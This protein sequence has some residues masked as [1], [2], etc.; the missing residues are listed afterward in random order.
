MTE[1]KQSEFEF[2]RHFSRRVTADFEGGAH[3][4]DGGLLLL[5]E[6]AEK[7]RLL[8][9]LG[10]CFRDGRAP[11]RRRHTVEE[12]LG[13]RIFALAAGYEDLNDHDE[14]RR[15]PLLA[16]AAGRRDPDEALAS[17]STLCRLEAGAAEGEGEDRYKRVGYDAAAI[18]ALLVELFLESYAE[19]PAE[20]VLDLDV[21]DTPLHGKQEGRFFHGY[22]GCYCYLPLYIFAGERL[23][24]VRL[25]TADQ[26]A[27]AG[28]L[29]EVERLVAAIRA[30]WPTT[31]IIVRGDAGFCRERLLGWCEQHGVDYV[32]GLAR[33]DRLRARIGEAMAAAQQE[34]QQTGRPARAFA[35]LRYRT[36]QSWSRSRRV[37]AKAEQ[38]ADKENPRYVVTSLEA[39][40]WGPRELYERLYCARGEMEN[41]IKEQL[42]LFADR[43][44]AATLRANQL[45]LYLSA[46]AY[47]LLE[48]L[49]RLGLQGTELARAQAT[50]I[51]LRLVKIGARLRLSARRLVV[52]MPTSYPYQA[53]FRQAWS[54][55]RC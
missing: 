34:Q 22:Y 14:L 28:A 3:S 31:R 27:S 15:D 47:V 50:T 44:S 9:R 53:V 52:S 39:A 43:V 35:E 23:L 13:Q 10:R 36:L 33:N 55:L 48:S 42:S 29:E 40:E 49:R 51:R 7:L 46:L 30:H 11:E 21:T 38:L 19:P 26:D 25:R 12:M 24:G 54:A 8:P 37:V 5:R 32:I 6:V 41:R 17:K 16:A 4:S 45:R 20:I 18:D 1:C 2:A